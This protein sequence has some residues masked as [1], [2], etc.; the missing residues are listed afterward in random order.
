MKLTVLLQFVRRSKI[1]FTVRLFPRCWHLWMESMSGPFLDCFIPRSCVFIYI[2][3]VCSFKMAVIMTHKP[4]KLSPRIVWAMPLKW[5]A[6][7]SWD[8]QVLLNGIDC[9]MSSQYWVKFF[10]VFA[11]A[12]RIAP[13]LNA[14]QSIIFYYVCSMC[15]DKQ[16][17][18]TPCI[19]T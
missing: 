15:A 2:Q 7:S 17:I 12:F 14:L 9:R 10:N 13:C 18:L 19:C 5:S 8:V 11:R 4:H 16:Q 3:I 1:K 6:E